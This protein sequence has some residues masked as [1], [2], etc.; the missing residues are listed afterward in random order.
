ME[1]RTLPTASGPMLH[2]RLRPTFIIHC[3]KP[4]CTFA[5]TARRSGQEVQALAA[6]LL[7]P[8]HNET[9]KE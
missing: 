5:A 1:L 2:V 6:H 9:P 3:P 8:A 4:G 7:G